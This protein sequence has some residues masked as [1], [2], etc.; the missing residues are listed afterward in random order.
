MNVWHDFISL[1][2]PAADDHKTEFSSRGA[3]VVFPPIGVD[4]LAR[5]YA[6]S[7]RLTVETSLRRFSR[8]QLVARS[9]FTAATD[10]MDFF[11]I[12]RTIA[13]APPATPQ[14]SQTKPFGQ[15]QHKRRMWSRHRTS[16]Q[17]QPS[18]LLNKSFTQKNEFFV[19]HQLFSTHGFKGAL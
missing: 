18:N 7:G 3:C 11:S 12:P 1:F 15:G 16:V 14:R 6:K 10:T 4:S 5:F 13:K 19:S 17:N 2:V 8:M 9:V